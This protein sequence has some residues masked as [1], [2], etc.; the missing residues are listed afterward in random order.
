MKS[1]A[2][3]ITD[4]EWLLR[5]VRREMFRTDKVPVIS[6]NAFEPRVKGRD[7]DTDGISFYRLACLTDPSD[8]LATVPP[9]RQD[10]YGIVRVSVS[11]LK[12]LGL[13]VVSK[14]DHRVRGHVV[15]P[16]LTAAAYQSDKVRF[17]PIKYKLA[18]EA[19]M[20]E[21]ILRRPSIESK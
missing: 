16:E 13:S 4:D 3:P 11:L 17:T 10:E 15:I 8:V 12:S 7:P 14:P 19:S 9:E 21:N 20:E 5:R 1:E 18:T 2:D 6:P